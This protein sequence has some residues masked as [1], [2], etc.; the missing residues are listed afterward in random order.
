MSNLIHREGGDRL[1]CLKKALVSMLI[2]SVWPR[3]QILSTRKEEVE[4]E[5]VNGIRKYNQNQN[6]KQIMSVLC[7]GLVEINKN[8]GERI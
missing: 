3:R 2:S 7:V 6:E 1:S 5:S 8:G 4:S